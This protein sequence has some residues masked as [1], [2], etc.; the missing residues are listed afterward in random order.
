[1]KHISVLQILTFDR[2]TLPDACSADTAQRA[3]QFAQ[4]MVHLI[5]LLHGTACQALRRD[6][7]LANLQRHK[8]SSEVPPS[9][10]SRLWVKL[11]V[12]AFCPVLTAIHLCCTT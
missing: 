7:D 10:S 4:V 8:S 6:P 11:P 9:V 2:Y 1:M 12:D 3:Q 5:S